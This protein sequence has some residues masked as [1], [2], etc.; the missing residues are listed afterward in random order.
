MNQ[1]TKFKSRGS[2]TRKTLLAKLL[3]T[4]KK[5]RNCIQKRD[6]TLEE[7]GVFEIS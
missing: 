5:K 7:D 6:D 1:T 3:K 4:E 2:R